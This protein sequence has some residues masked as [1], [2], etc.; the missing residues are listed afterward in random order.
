MNRHCSSTVEPG[1]RLVVAI[2]PELTIGLVRPSPLRSIAVERVERQAGRVDAEAP[3]RGLRAQNLA[4][5]REHERLRH[6]HDRERMI[7]VAARVSRAVDADHAEA[8]E[9]GLNV[10]QRRIDVGVRCRRGSSLKRSCAC[11]T[12]VRTTSGDGR[13]PVE[14]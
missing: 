10:G 7:G 12:T 2:A 4:D 11:D 9:I 6:A 5:E 13:R 1:A 14:T 8:E 3:A